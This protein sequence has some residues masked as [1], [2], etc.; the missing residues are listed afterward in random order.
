M[1]ILYIVILVCPLDVFIWTFR[2]SHESSYRNI[3]TRIF[4]WFMY[5]YGVAGVVGI[6]RIQSWNL[7]KFFIFTL[8]YGIPAI[9]AL[10]GY[11]TYLN[12]KESCVVNE[13][14]MYI[15]QTIDIKKEDGVVDINE[16]MAVN[17]QYWTHRKERKEKTV[18]ILPEPQQIFLY[19]LTSH[20]IFIFEQS[21]AV[22]FGRIHSISLATL[23]NLGICC[24]DSTFTFEIR[25]IVI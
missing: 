20:I 18:I 14:Q 11:Y 10:I 16:S 8:G 17:Y 21:N 1:L 5:A 9:V 12:K 25:A 23:V 24:D 22:A 13:D 19:S 2:I 7:A 6:F 3:G 15:K 4:K